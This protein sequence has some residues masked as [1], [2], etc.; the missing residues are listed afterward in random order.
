MTK[1]EAIKEL[2][3]WLD[4]MIQSGVPS[5]SAKRKALAYAISALSIKPIS[6]RNDGTLFINVLDA[7]KVHSVVV[8]DYGFFYKK[9]CEEVKQEDD[10]DYINDIPSE[11]LTE[12]SDL[13]SRADAITFVGEAIADGESWY[14]ALNKVPSVSVESK[15]TENNYDCDLISRTELREAL[16]NHKYNYNILDVL[17]DVFD[18]LDNALS[19]TATHDSTHECDISDLISRADAI[20]AINKATNE[21]NYQHEGEDWCCGLFQAE[22]LIQALP[23]VSAE[24]RG[25]NLDEEYPSL[26]TC[27]E[28]GAS[29]NDTIPWDCEIN[30]CP[31]CGARMENTK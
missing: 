28:C 17:S 24:R 5:H 12:P 23:A 22:Q 8:T 4:Q 1:E 9:F 20:K 3:D 21:P 6:V 18:I 29:C 11:Y 13:I 14:D 7:E 10:S 30:Y 15:V 26:F 2:C 27:S 19:L 31:N 25:T 16:E